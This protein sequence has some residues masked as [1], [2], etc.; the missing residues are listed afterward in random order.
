MFQLYDRVKLKDGRTGFICVI[1]ENN[2]DMLLDVELGNFKYD[3][4]CI[5]K[6][7]IEKKINK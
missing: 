2:F 4:I 7:D 1:F 3:T 5:T 6:D